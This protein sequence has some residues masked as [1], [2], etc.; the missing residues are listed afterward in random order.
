MF[1]AARIASSG[2]ARVGRGG[3]VGGIG[4]VRRGLGMGGIKDCGGRGGLG[5]RKDRRV[6]WQSSSSGMFVS[7]CIVGFLGLLVLFGIGWCN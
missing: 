6:R 5:L 7:N 2:V 3:L 1:L 4:T